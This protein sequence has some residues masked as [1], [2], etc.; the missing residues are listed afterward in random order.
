MTETGRR[1]QTAGRDLSESMAAACPALRAGAAGCGTP[2]GPALA[3]LIALLEGFCSELAAGIV[4]AGDA[5]L[6]AADTYQVVDATVMGD[7]G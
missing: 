4:A 7:D 2:A 6:A 5:T 3:E 1:L